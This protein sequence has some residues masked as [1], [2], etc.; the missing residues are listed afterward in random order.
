MHDDSTRPDGQG[1]GRE[2]L[3]PDDAAL[4]RALDRVLPAPEPVVR[5]VDVEAALASVRA[6][7]AADE[8]LDA[9]PAK[10]ALT[11]SRTAAP[12]RPALPG[13]SR[14]RS[15]TGLAAAAAIVAAAGL[16]TWRLMSA[17]GTSAAAVAAAIVYETRVGV[18]DSMLLADGSHVTLAPGSR[19]SVAADFAT[20]R[21]VQLE[22]AA[23]FDVRHDEAH[24]FT[25]R[26]GG[27]EIRDIGTAFSVNT[28]AGGAV[29]VA[30]TEGVVALRGAG[31][32]AA[33]ELNAGDRGVA[34]A[35]GAVDGA[36]MVERGAVTPSS[37]AWTHG[38]LVYRDAPLREVR[39]DFRRWFGVELDV[40]DSSLASRTLTASL[41]ADS[42]AQALQIIA[43]ALGADAVQRGDT[44]VLRRA[45]ARQP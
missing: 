1:D 30:V 35:P 19:L 17:S 43:I 34:G 41:R 28:D 26:S 2:E 38:E 29:V 36:V 40:A 20:S 23:F 10:P 25:V 12:A 44:V 3:S 8:T 16:G 42:E 18:R 15:T 7:I 27:A 11:V 13:R 14:M 21:T 24:P 9:T 4:Y 32:A 6:R 33:V 31:S 22:G 37:V 45:A 39:A 5:Q